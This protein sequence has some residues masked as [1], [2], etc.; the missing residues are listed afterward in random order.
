MS[1]CDGEEE[2]L[3]R[4]D[5]RS[6]SEDLAEGATDEEVEAVPVVVGSSE[7]A[8]TEGVDSLSLETSATRISSSSSLRASPPGARPGTEVDMVQDRGEIKAWRIRS[9]DEQARL[10][11]LE[12]VKGQLGEVHER[13]GH[14][15]EALGPPLNFW[16]KILDYKSKLPDWTFL[17]IAQMRVRD[18]KRVKK[19]R[20][21][22]MCYCT[23]IW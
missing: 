14:Q 11:T 20:N 1:E 8:L 21:V 4:S 2:S 10:V 5:L 12:L 18:F 22:D 17:K 19:D 15:R 13:E 7:V 9:N 6:R 23:S 3:G 16:S